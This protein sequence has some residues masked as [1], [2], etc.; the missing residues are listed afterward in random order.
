[1]AVYQWKKSS[2]LKL[3]AQKVGETLA[4][5]ELKS[6]LTPQAVVDASR[7]KNSLLHDYFEWDDT[8]AAEKYRETQASYL[9]RQIEIVSTGTSEP[10]RAFVSVTCGDETASRTYINVERALSTPQTREEVLE[11]ALS[12]LRAFERKYAGLEELADIIDAIR[13]VAA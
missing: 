6:G 11:R 4:K 2:Q 1:M 7:R 12:E 10:V 5:I 3:D 13:R 8:I 9:I